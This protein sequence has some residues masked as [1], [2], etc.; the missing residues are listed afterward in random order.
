VLNVRGFRFFA[1]RHYAG[2]DGRGYDV[3]EWRISCNHSGFAIASSPFYD[4]A[5]RR[6]SDVLANKFDSYIKKVKNRPRATWRLP[7]SA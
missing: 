4:D 6:A 2:E 3:W 7:R 5:L 1:H